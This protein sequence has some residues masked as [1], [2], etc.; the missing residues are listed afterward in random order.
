MTAELNAEYNGAQLAPFGKRVVAHLIDAAPV[1]IPVVVMLLIGILNFASVASRVD[2]TSTI[3]YES[4]LYPSTDASTGW[5]VGTSE[6]NIVDGLLFYSLLLTFPLLG[7]GVPL[8]LWSTVVL[9]GRTGRS[10]GKS[11]MG[12]RLVKQD[13]GMPPGAPLALGRYFAHW[14]DSAVFYVGYVL[15]L[16]TPKRQTIADMVCNTVVVLD[17]QKL[18]PSTSSHPMY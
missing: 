15:P 11:V 14:L 18:P 4:D 8:T 1:I 10:W 2:S 12:I 9:Q 13:N 6:T 7:I 16:F 3:Q 17:P 5:V